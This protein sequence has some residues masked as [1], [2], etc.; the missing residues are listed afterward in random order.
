MGYLKKIGLTKYESYVYSSLMRN[1]RSSAIEI[2]DKSKVPPTAVY[3][4]LKALIKKQLVQKIGGDPATYEAL[5]INASI[6]NLIEKKQKELEQLELETINYL[7]ELST[8][9]SV[10]KEREIVTLS[11]GKTFS[12]EIYHESI[13]KVNKTFFIMGWRFEKIGDRYNFLKEF[14]KAI[15]RGVDVRIIV[16]GSYEK[17]RELVEAY[18]KSG[19]KLKFFPLENISIFIVDEKE[20][21]ITL[22][23]RNLP[24][25]YNMHI[26]DESLSQALNTYFLDTWEKAREVN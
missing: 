13:K 26:H 8:E 24:E 12:S 9:K 1:G 11:K 23:N 18:Q 15:K 10:P 14:K 16:T 17:N 25:K 2:S 5:P 20:C 3:P 19:I 6:K 22:K 4:N 7:E 21:K